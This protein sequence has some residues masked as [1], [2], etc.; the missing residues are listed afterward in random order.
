MDIQKSDPLELFEEFYQDVKNQEL[1]SVQK[2][3]M[4]ELL[5][6]AGVIREDS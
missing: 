2:E 1:S 6:K 4:Q 5:E 3:M